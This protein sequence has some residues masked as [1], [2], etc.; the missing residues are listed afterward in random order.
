MEAG[1]LLV[2]LLNRRIILSG[3]DEA[4]S[5]PREGEKLGQRQ[6]NVG[7]AD[8]NNSE[9]SYIPIGETEVFC[10]AGGS[11]GP[12]NSEGTQP[13]KFFVGGLR[14]QGGGGVVIGAGVVVAPDVSFTD[15]QLRMV[16]K[17]RGK[18]RFLCGGLVA[19]GDGWQ[20][21]ALAEVLD[22]A[23]GNSLS[24]ITIS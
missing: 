1:C 19:E 16:S 11:W 24:E 2:R 15:I 21:T 13:T 17:R 12:E 22:V 4:R 7:Q 20:S 10:G 3:P 18:T 14:A 5:E 9:A 6:P 8:T 23:Q